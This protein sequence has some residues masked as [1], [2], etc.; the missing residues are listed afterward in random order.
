MTA[1][2]SK[3]GKKAGPVDPCLPFSLVKPA[4]DW[5]HKRRITV[6]EAYT[7][8]QVELS[9]NIARAGAWLYLDVTNLAGSG[10]DYGKTLHVFVA[11]VL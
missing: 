1:T 4:I 8:R 11:P 2:C 6:S 3:L 9:E 7:I 5:I 10:H